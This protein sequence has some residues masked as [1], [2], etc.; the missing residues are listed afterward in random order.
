MFSA[1]LRP[2]FR[3]L[4][5]TLLTACLA[6]AAGANADELPKGLFPDSPAVA[7]FIRVSD[8]VASPFYAEVKS[9]LADAGAALDKPLNKKAKLTLN[10][11]ASVAI[12]G[13]AATQPPVLVVRLCE[14]AEESSFNVGANDKA[15]TVAD[16][17]LH[18]V[19]SLG[20]ASLIDQQTLLLGPTESLRQLLRREGESQ[21][22]PQLQSAWNG[23][24]EAAPFRVVVTGEGLARSLGAPSASNAFFHD[25]LRKIRTVAVTIDVKESLELRVVCDC[26][27][28]AGA[29]AVD[30]AVKLATAIYLPAA[31]AE[32]QAAF[33]ER[34]S[35]KAGTQLLLNVKLDAAAVAYFVKP[36]VAELAAE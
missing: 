23:L 34:K 2:L 27:D 31:P 13:D 29:A 25:T 4:T 35:E 14:E 1:S 10:D 30:G 18:P 36:V 33:S 6:S 5:A 19:D 20:A 16:F 15:E 32:V 21:F 22:A 26:Q 11:V 7:G 12:A 9:K 3:K 8:V 24:D 17:D 28:E